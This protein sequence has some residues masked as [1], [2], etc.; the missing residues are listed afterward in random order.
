MGAG[1]S[2]QASGNT[3]TTQNSSNTKPS[4]SFF[5]KINPFGAKPT[6]AAPG[7]NKKNNNK[8][9]NPSGNTA[10]PAPAPPQENPTTAS[11]ENG[12]K[13]GRKYKKMKK[14]KK[15]VKKAKKSVKKAK[16]SVKKAKKS[17]KKG[18]KRTTRK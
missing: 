1:P 4:G 18:K 5:N 11:Q 17:V 13:G 15:S 3:A 6:P 8:N 9:K 2:T 12:S 16:K 14:V 7:N 10:A